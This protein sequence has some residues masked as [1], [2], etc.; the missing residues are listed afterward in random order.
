MAEYGEWT[1]KGASLSDVTAIKEY[2]IDRQFIVRGIREGKLEYHEGSIWGN[3]ILKL[4]RSQLEQFIRDELGA[5]Y[6]RKE[7]KK[8]ELRAIKKEISILKK[9][10]ALLQELKTRLESDEE[11]SVL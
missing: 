6:L 4:L 5:D 8:T 7:K 10:L 11:S 1:R 2:G 9:R 3:P